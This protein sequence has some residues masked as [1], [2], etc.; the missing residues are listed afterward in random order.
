[1][2][3]DKGRAVPLCPAPKRWV[4]LCY[5]IIFID[6][7]DSNVISLPSPNALPHAEHEITQAGC[8]FVVDVFSSYAKHETTPSRCDFVFGVISSPYHTSWWWNNMSFCH[9]FA[10]HIC[11]MRNNTILGVVLCS[12][13]LLPPRMNFEGCLLNI[14]NLREFGGN[15]APVATGQ[16]FGGYRYGAAKNSPQDT[17]VHHYM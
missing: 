6:F 5:V 12:D 13:P 11:R 9:L 3:G 7:I 16:E 1:M 17:R 4:I 8:D 15:P 2:G 14:L 10:Y